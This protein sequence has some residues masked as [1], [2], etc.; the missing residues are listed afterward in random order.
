[1]ASKINVAY[2]EEDIVEERF[3]SIRRNIIITTYIMDSNGKVKCMV[4]Q[5]SSLYGCIRS[6]INHVYILARVQIPERMK[7]ELLTFIAGMEITVMAEKQM[8][9]LKISK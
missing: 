4:H 1:M 7:R 6:A 5:S 3:R 8:I 9:G 2:V